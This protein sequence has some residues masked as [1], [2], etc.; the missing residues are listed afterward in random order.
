MVVN[1]QQMF[2]CL[3]CGS[4][5]PDIP[6]L[7]LF[8]AALC[9]ALCYKVFN[10][11][12]LFSFFFLCPGFLP[13]GNYLFHL[14]SVP[15]VGWTGLDFNALSPLKR[16][17]GSMCIYSLGPP[18]SGHSDWFTWSKLGWTPLP[19]PLAIKKQGFLFPVVTL[20]LQGLSTWGYICKEETRTE[21]MTKFS[22]KL[23]TSLTIVE[24]RFIFWIFSYM[25]SIFFHKVNWVHS[26]SLVL[27]GKCPYYYRKIFLSAASGPLCSKHPL[28]RAGWHSVTI[29]TA[30]VRLWELE[31]LLSPLAPFSLNCCRNPNWFYS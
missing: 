19:V 23:I 24:A 25:A 31:F 12:F 6:H 21:M 15:V 22:G 4:P 18:P 16:G 3:K 27:N 30:S 5:T 26:V 29:F 9:F 28:Q 2:K 17:K 7:F 10:V 20:L 11:W 14:C 1:T 8:Q 13:M